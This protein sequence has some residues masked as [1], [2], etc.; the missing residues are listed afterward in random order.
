M[1]EDQKQKGN[2]EG[3]PKSIA[4][5]NN[6]ILWDNHRLLKAPN[7][8][9]RETFFCAK[10]TLELDAGLV[11]E[12]LFW[13]TPVK[14]IQ[15]LKQEEL[16][17]GPKEDL[18]KLERFLVSRLP[19]EF[20]FVGKVI[21]ADFDTD[22]FYAMMDEN[23][24][25]EIL[26]IITLYFH[27]SFDFINLFFIGSS[28]DSLI[29]KSTDQKSRFLQE[30]KDIQFNIGLFLQLERYQYLFILKSIRAFRLAISIGKNY[31]HL[32][33]AILISTVE[34]LAEKYFKFLTG[35]S[36]ET[37]TYP[38]VEETPMHKKVTKILEER[39]TGPTSAKLKADIVES[40]DT[41]YLEEEYEDIKNKYINFCLL[42]A[43]A[44]FINSHLGEMLDD[45]YYLRSK[46][47]HSGEIIRITPEMKEITFNRYS[48]TGK[49][50][51]AK[52]SVLK[53]IPPLT[54]LEMFCK[55]II[56]KLVG[57]LLKE[58]PADTDLFTPYDLTIPQ[59]EIVS[60]KEPK[61]IASGT[62]ILKKD[63]IQPFDYIEAW[64]LKLLITDTQNIENNNGQEQAWDYF[65]EYF[66]N[67]VC[68]IKDQDWLAGAHYALLLLY[69]LKRYNEMK[70]WITKYHF[71]ETNPLHWF[72]FNFLSYILAAEK[73]FKESLKLLER[74]LSLKLDLFQKASVLDSRGDVFHDAEDNKNAIRSYQESLT[75]VPEGKYFFFHKQTLSHLIEICSQEGL[76][77]LIEKYQNLQKQYFAEQTK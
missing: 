57:F 46:I 12:E 33:L 7:A 5:S 1:V 76:K 44:P 30:F 4:I 58:K 20:L 38:P 77:E 39:L 18:Q 24:I 21:T 3:T 14:N 37:L 48:R 19:G 40:I 6:E 74:L 61:P 64:K 43:P 10:S 41:I 35:N 23:F 66:P 75:L 31:P 62:I 53:R 50:K 8:I 28:Y 60:M 2:T 59:K 47:F 72:A 9:K 67:I 54:Q 22:Q 65:Y 17:D 73:E 68:D 63:T 26:D 70:E 45:W 15:I 42:V 29:A 52:D 55:L 49:L 69:K 36:K 51:E 25:S 32:E 11:V 56:I 71:D 27:T 13:L 34:P 16:G